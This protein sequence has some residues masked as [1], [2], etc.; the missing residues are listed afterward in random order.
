MAKPD[1]PPGQSQLHTIKNTNTGETK[2]I[3]Q[4]EWRTDGK[5]LKAEGW[6]RVDDSGTEVPE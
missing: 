2:Q 3:T 5:Q 4:E 6:V 1:S